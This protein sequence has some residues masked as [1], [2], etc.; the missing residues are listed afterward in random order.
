MEPSP[1]HIQ[2]RL[3]P[4]ALLSSSFTDLLFKEVCK[5]CLCR[6]GHLLN[7]V[8]PYRAIP[9]DYLS[10]TPLLPAMGFLVSQHGQLG[11]TPPPSFLSV[12]PLESMRSGGAIPPLKR[13]ISAI[14]ARYPTKTRQTGA[15]HLCDT[16][17]KGYCA[18]WGGISHWAAK[19]LNEG[20][21][22]PPLFQGGIG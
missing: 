19:L 2:C 1:G 11:A 7:L 5:G 10:D 6:R 21:K 13:G 3:L 20:V 12:S 17:S 22:T 4:E 14:L 9:R 15:I 18:I 16:I 8:A